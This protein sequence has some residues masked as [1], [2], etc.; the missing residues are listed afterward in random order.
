MTNKINKSTP[1][2]QGSHTGTAH[3]FTHA[4]MLRILAYLRPAKEAFTV[5]PE[6]WRR[7]D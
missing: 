5:A 1:L 3:L 2:R 6:F 7:Y 4:K